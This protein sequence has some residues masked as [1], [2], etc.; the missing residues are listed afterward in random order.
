MW[1]FS[2]TADVHI[3]LASEIHCRSVMGPEN[4]RILPF[5][6]TMDIQESKLLETRGH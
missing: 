1:E 6:L 3:L 4:Q 5:V 2:I